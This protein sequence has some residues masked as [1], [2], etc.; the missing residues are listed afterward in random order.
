MSVTIGAVIAGRYEVLDLIAQGGMSTVYRARRRSDGLI[1]ALKIL[2]AQ[3]A[4]DSEFIE[5][6]AREAR[7]AE[8]LAHPNIVKVLESGH[9]GETYFIAME[10]VN[11]LDL[12]GHLRR[13]GRLEPADAERIAGS[14]CEALDYAHHQGIV[15][16]D[17]KPQNILIASD[18]T[19]KVTDFGIARALAAVT[20]TQPGEV[21]GTVQY[22]SPE[23]AR[24]A[25]VGRT[26][27]LYALGVVLYEM[28]TGRLPFEGDSPIAIALKHLHDPTP[29]LRLVQPDVPMRLEGIVLRAMAK[30]AEDR[31][32]SAREMADDLAGKTEVWKETFTEDEAITRTF[33]VVEDPAAA[34][35]SRITTVVIGAVVLLILAGGLWAGWT[36]VSS[37]LNVP[38][39]EMPPVVGRSLP[40]AEEII[41][42]AGLVL[43]VTER[44][45]SATVPPDIIISQD[46]PPGK[47]LKQGRHVGVVISLG[48]RLVEVPDLVK[49]TVQEAQLAIESANL[50]VGALQDGYD[51]LVKPGVVMRQDP[52]AGSRVAVDSPLTLVISR[53]PL[54]IQMPDVVGKPLADARRLLEEQ[55]LVIA[56]LNTVGSTDVEP[57]VVMAQTP[58]A[59]TKMRPGEVSITLI[60]S[61]KPG[62][63]GAPPRAPVITAEPQPVETPAGRPEPTPGPG[64]PTPAPRPAA[65]PRI[66]PAPGAV[67]PPPRPSPT[68]SPSIIR[69]TRVQV[70]VPEGGVHTVKI[71]VIDE[72]GVHTVYQAAHSPGERI[73]QMIG[74]RG[75]TIIQVYVDNRLVQEVRP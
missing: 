27:D 45:N 8:T 40:Q 66:E 26:S 44:A 75:Y 50:K 23:Q 54:L 24:G 42:Q 35:R 9:D 28:L 34:R 38:E 39:A 10:Y 67:Q 69:R 58:A 51:E 3:Y 20:I 11:G 60:V 36:T 46:Q 2:R 53:G 48:A 21:L 52:P 15:H 16:R 32:A 41:R 22:L 47:R 33:E 65:T 73:D 4:A 61:S 18:G 56:Q 17:V 68:T 12:K 43:D 19:V 31:Y 6:F 30:R 74:S 59:G 57:G 1:V 63:E 29:R 72:T 70:V 49:K 14:V 62:Q 64:A 13:V 71:V 7:A 25:S 5:R 55:G 37:Y